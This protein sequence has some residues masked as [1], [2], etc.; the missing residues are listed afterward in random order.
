MSLKNSIDSNG[1]RNRY[2]PVCRAVPQP[3]KPPRAPIIIIIIII[4]IMPVGILVI[5]MKVYFD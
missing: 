4:I 3:T 2:P 1:N 5:P